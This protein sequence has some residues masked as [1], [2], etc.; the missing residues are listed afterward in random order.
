MTDTQTQTTRQALES[1]SRGV[2]MRLAAAL[3]ALAAGAA[4]LVVAILL[5]RSALS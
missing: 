3:L 4:A 2:R 5:V 1:A